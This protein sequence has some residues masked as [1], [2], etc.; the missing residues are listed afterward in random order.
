MEYVVA[1]DIIIILLLILCFSLCCI[2]FCRSQW[3]DLKIKRQISPQETVFVNP[4][5]IKHEKIL[6]LV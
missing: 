1:R 5:R 3:R 2:C 4:M 6:R